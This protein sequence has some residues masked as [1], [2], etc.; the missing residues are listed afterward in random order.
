[1]NNTE[2]KI[3]EL[4]KA[5]KIEKNAKQKRRYNTVLLYLKGYTLSQIADI[6]DM[7]E[8]TIRNNITL[9]KKDGIEGLKIKKKPGRTKKLTDEQ[10]KEL[11]TIIET[12]TPNDVGFAPF[13]NWTA[14]IVC[15]LVEKKYN[16]KFSE[17]GMRNLFDRIKLSYTRPTY[18][19]EKADPEKQEIFKSEF[20]IVKKN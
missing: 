4:S 15:K 9:Y 2:E 16:V 1:M 17:R 19:L 6:Y 5:I 18:T 11:Y 8:Q 14:P 12:Q 3:N 10:E 7:A 13:M 20:E